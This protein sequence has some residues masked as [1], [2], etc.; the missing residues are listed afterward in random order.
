MSDETA[1]TGLGLHSKW[2]L[3]TLTGA[4]I[5]R[6][7]RRTY[8]STAVAVLSRAPSISR[9]GLSNKNDFPARYGECDARQL[10]DIRPTTVAKSKKKKTENDGTRFQNVSNECV[11]DVENRRTLKL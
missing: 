2:S 6:C 3:P 4:R 8:Y 7:Y 11:I 5:P 1:S 10:C 9:I